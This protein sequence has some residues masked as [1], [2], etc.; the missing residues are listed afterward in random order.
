MFEIYF[1][2]LWLLRTTPANMAIIVMK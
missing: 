2:V 1:Y